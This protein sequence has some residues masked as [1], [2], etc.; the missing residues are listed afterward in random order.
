M[1]TVLIRKIGTPLYDKNGINRDGVF[2][3]KS[4]YRGTWPSLGY[5]K[6]H[7][8][9]I[10]DDRYCSFPAVLESYMDA[11]FV[12]MSDDFTLFET[13]PVK[14]FFIDKIIDFVKNGSKNMWYESKPQRELAQKYLTSIGIDVIMVTQAQK[15][16]IEI[17]KKER[18]ELARLKAKYEK[19]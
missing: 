5:A 4:S 10:F 1:P 13:I 3:I 16:A 11:E 14:D 17:G 6:G 7:V 12:V 15:R 18:A 8:S 9:Q 2:Y 19:A